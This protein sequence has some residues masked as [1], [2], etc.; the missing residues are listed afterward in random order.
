MSSRIEQR[1]RW[2]IVGLSVLALVVRLPGLNTGLWADEIYSTLYAFRTPFPAQFLEFH[3]DNK[4]PFYSV[5]AHSA[6]SLLGEAPWTLRL[7][8]VLFGVASV[9]MLFALGRR[10]ATRREAAFAAL[11]LAVSYH[12][13]WFSQNARGYSILGFCAITSTWL[14]L[15]VLD[16]GR[17]RD[18]VAFAVVIALG[19]YTHLTFVFAVLAQFLVVAVLLWRARRVPEARARASSAAAAFVGGGLLAALMYAPMAARVVN[20]F[21]HKESALAGISSPAWAAAEAVRVLLVGLSGGS[22]VLATVGL[23]ILGVAGVVGLSGAADYLRREPRVAALLLLPA[24][25][26][27]GGALA[28]RGTMYPRF[29]FLLAGFALLVGVRGVVRSSELV[30]RVLGRPR[31]GPTLATAVLVLGAAG[32]AATLPRNW[33]LPKQDYEGALRFVEGEAARSGGTIATADMTTEIYGRYF[34]RSWH[35]V[36]DVATLVQLRKSGPV[37]FVYTFPRYLARYDASLA[38]WVERECRAARAFV[39]TVGGG[40]VM[41]CTLRATASA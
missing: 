18:S 34:G 12:H 28:S 25:T 38:A 24:V 15:R 32:S 17:R 21:L 35:D 8:A 39:G 3:G 16:E 13:A 29:F 14:L 27:L 40:E 11:L 6:A 23:V 26:M 41:V 33:R 37:W 20:F 4:H 36:R 2:L 7:P 9:P 5:L 30:G 1:D 31:L 22:A 19:A 10:I